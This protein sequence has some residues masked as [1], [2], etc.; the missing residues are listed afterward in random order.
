MRQLERA[1]V[2]AQL[3]VGRR[4]R[5]W[6][7]PSVFALLDEFE[8]HL[9]IRRGGKGGASP[10]I[11]LEKRGP[12]KRIYD[13]LSKVRD[14]RGKRRVYG[15]PPRSPTAGRSGRSKTEYGGAEKKKLQSP[16]RIM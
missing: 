9:A 16:P 13:P 8:R 4:N 5:A 7:A 15:A 14:R 6:E 12:A 1:G 3:T 10:L 2:L 11:S